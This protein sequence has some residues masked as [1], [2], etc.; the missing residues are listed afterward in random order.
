MLAKSSNMSSRFAAAV[1]WDPELFKRSTDVHHQ[2]RISSTPAQYPAVSSESY[3][4]VVDIQRTRHTT[5]SDQASTEESSI[6]SDSDQDIGAVLKNGKYRCNV[7][8]CAEKIYKRPAELRRHYNTIHAA[9]KPEFWCQVMFCNRSAAA[10][11]KTFHRK[12]RLQDHMRKM[13][14]DQVNTNIDIDMCEG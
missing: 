11:G 2:A 8:A 12:Y 6:D 14:A 9:Q 10:G 13:H 4:Q 5:L 7:L 1:P 3:S